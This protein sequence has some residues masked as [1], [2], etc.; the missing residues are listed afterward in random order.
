MGLVSLLDAPNPQIIANLSREAAEAFRKTYLRDR[1]NKFLR[2][3]IRGGFNAIFA[4]GLAFAISRG[5][6]IALPSIKRATELL[7]AADARHFAG[8]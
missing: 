7:P 5:G 4:R 2:D 8:Q 1:W 6:R 3:R